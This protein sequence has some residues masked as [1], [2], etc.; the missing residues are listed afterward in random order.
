MQKQP[1]KK[2]LFRYASRHPDEPRTVSDT[3][4][5]LDSTKQCF[6][7]DNWSG[8]FTGSAWVVDQSRQWILMTHHFQ[9]DLWLQLGGHAE[10]RTNL[11][12]VALEEAKEESGL[13]HFK[14][15][16][17]EIFDLDIH[18]IPQYNG[19][20]SHLHYDI[21]FIFEAQHGDEEIIISDESHDVAWVHVNDVLQKNPESSMVR[22]LEKTKKV[23]PVINNEPSR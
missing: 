7:R 4:Q 14:S 1:L 6:D 10:G 21:R 3:I 5:F 2:L 13:S 8:H 19:T 23:S 20:P 12:N 22:M 17:D 11:L 16:S 9:L 15:L 18:R